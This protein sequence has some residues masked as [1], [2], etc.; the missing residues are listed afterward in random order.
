MNTVPKPK[1]IFLADDDT[2]DCILFE[3]AL[4]EI[5]NSSQLTTANDGIQLMDLLHTHSTL[6]DVIFLDLNMPRKN[7]FE[8]LAEIRERPQLKNIP[9]V[10]FST[11]AQPEAV[12]NVYENGANCFVCKPN[13][14]QQL[15]LAIQHVL[16]INWGPDQK[17]LPQEQFIYQ[18]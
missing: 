6:P 16:S 9:I 11:T 15:K 13:T 3:D 8:C 10:I 17:P 7:G 1:N 2:D 14:F 5:C 12:K 18:P 4:R